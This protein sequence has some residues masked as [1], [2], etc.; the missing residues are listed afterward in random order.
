[1][2]DHNCRKIIR[3]LSDPKPD[4]PAAI[5]IVQDELELNSI[6]RASQPGML[7][8]PEPPTLPLFQMAAMQ[9]E[10]IDQ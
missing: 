3:L 1:M 4:I 7:A 10:R 8:E 5:R 6:K 9:P 2:Q